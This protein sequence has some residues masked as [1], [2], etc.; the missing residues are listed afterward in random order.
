MSSHSSIKVVLYALLANLG[1]ALTKFAGAYFTKSTS[2]LAEAIHSVAD[3]ANQVFL[4]IGGK[5][6]QKPPDEKH[7]LGYGRESFFW[8]FLVA[9]LLFSMGGLFAI[10]EGAHKLHAADSELNRP[11]IGVAILLV[12]ILLEGGSF[13]ACL[14]E[15]RL[16]NPGMPLWKWFRTSSASDLVVIF[17]EDLAAL[18]G[19]TIAFLF[20]GI[21][22]LTGDAV[23]DA[24]GSIFIGALLISVSALLAVEV[25]SLLIGEAPSVKYQDT[26]QNL[27]GQIDPQMKILRF[28]SLVTGNNEVLVSLKVT[29]GSQHLSA[30]LVKSINEVEVLVKKKFPEIKWLFVEPDTRD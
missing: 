17:M 14:K 6:A 13:F 29:P 24:I 8:S 23:W 12:S 21:A 22:L 25:K 20:L 3:C 1:I 9:I 15:V 4:L 10:Y 11:Y 7:P 2:L 28:V 18:L 16:Q 27:F 19:L 5:R 30:D 26:I